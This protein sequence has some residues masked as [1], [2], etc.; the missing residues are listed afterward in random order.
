MASI[1]CQSGIPE[2]TIMDVTFAIRAQTLTESW[3]SDTTMQAAMHA[4]GGKYNKQKQYEAELKTTQPLQPKQ[5]KEPTE[6]YFDA[7]LKPIKSRILDVSLI[8]PTW[9]ATSWQ[10]GLAP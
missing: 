2:S 7:L 10:F 5:G 3:A 8:S 4:F 9:M 1:D 6:A